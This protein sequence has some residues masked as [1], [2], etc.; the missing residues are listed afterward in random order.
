MK[1]EFPDPTKLRNST[2]LIGVI[3]LAISAAQLE[4]DLDK[5]ISFLGLPLTISNRNLVLYALMGVSGYYLFRYWY[6]SM[7][8]RSTWLIRAKLQRE[9]VFRG[10]GIACL[11]KL[12]STDVVRDRLE[13]I[14]HCGLSFDNCTSVKLAPVEGEDENWE[15]RIENLRGYRFSTIL[16]DL[17]FIAP[18][19]VNIAALAFALGNI[20]VTQ[21]G[22][23]AESTF[24]TLDGGVLW[25]I[26]LVLLA[27]GIYLVSVSQ[28]RNS[29]GKVFAGLLV[30]GA[31]VGA[32][33]MGWNQYSTRP[34]VVNEL[35]GLRLGMTPVEATLAL[36]KAVNFNIDRKY[37]VNVKEGK[38]QLDPVVVPASKFE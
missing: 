2:L 17:D 32:G 16:R 14:V 20:F 18:A 12:A 19:I 13:S 6:Y 1:Y 28:E 38:T 36:G 23:Q 30:A 35:A 31:V 22:V 10:D 3:L 7:R 21:F 15:I 25:S 8:D 27:V 11:K 24:M 37:L 26:I 5:E 4:I 33:F 34:H 9:F 29:F